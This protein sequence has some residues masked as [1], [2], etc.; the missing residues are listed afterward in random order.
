ATDNVNFAV[1]RGE[2]NCLYSK[3]EWEATRQTQAEPQSRSSE[4]SDL[5]E[6]SSSIEHR[7]ST[8][9]PSTNSS[10]QDDELR[11]ASDVN[12]PQA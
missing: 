4:H 11:L 7:K 3:S 10:E 6:A 12:N 9:S 8:E 5:P 1:K 2:I